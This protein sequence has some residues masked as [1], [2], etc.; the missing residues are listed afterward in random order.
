MKRTK[1][2]AV[3]VMIAL[4]VITFAAAALVTTIPFRASASGAVTAADPDSDIV[5]YRGETY[6]AAD[7]IRSVARSEASVQ[8]AVVT[9]DDPIVG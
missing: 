6:A 7:F 9:Q 2:I 1:A 3:T 5:T 8:S 4:A